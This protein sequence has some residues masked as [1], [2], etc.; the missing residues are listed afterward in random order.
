[1]KKLV[2]ALCLLL[3]SA[4]LL[5][6]STYAWFSMN[7][8]VT[9]NGMAVKARAEEGLVI[10]NAVAGTYDQTA[11]SSKTSVAELYPG[12]SADLVTFLHSTSTDPAD[13][14]T[15]Q[16]YTSGTAWVANSGVYGNYVVH[17][18]YIRSSADATLNVGSLDVKSVTA[19]VNG[20]TASAEL[21]KALRVG[22]KIDGA[23]AVYIYA[24]I[25]GF[26]TPVSVQNAAGDYSSVAAD[27]T[28]VAALAGNTES[29]SSV[30]AIPAKSAN[31]TH[32]EV[33]VW[34]EG[35]DEHCI[36]N[37]LVPNLDR[38]DITVVFGYTAV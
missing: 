4:L 14:N 22:V 24:P 17:D 20:A 10:S 37:N 21:N 16:A 35:E 5:G 1:M 34:Y 33:F 36:S 15:Q 8:T 27:R 19:T 3:I 13:E 38:L 29:H 31:G 25:A 26:T 23:N 18:F 28:S 6:T 12:S 30:T 2:P 7:T 32:V 11:A 9:A